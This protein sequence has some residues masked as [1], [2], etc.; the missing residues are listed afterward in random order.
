[1]THLVP[2]EE[3]AYKINYAC[4]LGTQVGLGPRVLVTRTLGTHTFLL[5]N[6]PFVRGPTYLA[7]TLPLWSQVNT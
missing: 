5:T 6:V 1:M 2:L 3:Y 7:T 4:V